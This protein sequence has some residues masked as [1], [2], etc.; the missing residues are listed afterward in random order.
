MLENAIYDRYKL[1]YSN[2]DGYLDTSNTGI[3]Y[4][5]GLQAQINTVNGG[6]SNEHK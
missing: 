5:S 3:D 1:L 4:T 6:L 2:S